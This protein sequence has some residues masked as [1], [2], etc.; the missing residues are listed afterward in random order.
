MPTSQ[1]EL[2]REALA[3]TA[4]EAQWGE[5]RSWWDSIIDIFRN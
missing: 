3:R 2:N 1:A 4:S 5:P